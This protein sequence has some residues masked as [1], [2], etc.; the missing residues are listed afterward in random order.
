MELVHNNRPVKQKMKTLLLSLA[1]WLSLLWLIIIVIII[2]N[3]IIITI[4][5]I[6]IIIITSAC[7]SSSA[8]L[9]TGILTNYTLL[10]TTFTITDIMI[11]RIRLWE[12]IYKIFFISLDACHYWPQLTVLREAENKR[13]ILKSNKTDSPPAPATTICGGLKWIFINWDRSWLVNFL[14]HKFIHQYS[15]SS[16]TILWCKQFGLVVTHLS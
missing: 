11:V 5:D 13:K 1:R 12:C 9:Q 4:N 15:V 8:L 10:K 14:K 16:T 6:I 3:I 2:I 7:A